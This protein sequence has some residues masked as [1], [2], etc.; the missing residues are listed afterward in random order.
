MDIQATLDLIG[1]VG[2]LG[3]IAVGGLLK[4]NSELD[5]R[6]IYHDKRHEEMK[7]QMKEYREETKKEMKELKDENKAD[8]AMYIRSIEAFELSQNHSS[9]T[10][11]KITS[12]EH[13]IE[14]IRND[15]R[16]L[17]N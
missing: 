15:I 3:A 2:L 1:Q 13:H 17:K 6:D 16:D 9:E 14:E 4:L 11:N 5:K 12:I 8:K 10:S 7:E